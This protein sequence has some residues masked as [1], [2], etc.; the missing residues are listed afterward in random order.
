MKKKREFLKW[1]ISCLLT[2]CFLFIS[3]NTVV[4]ATE[5]EGA[6]V[7]FNS[8]VEVEKYEID[9]GYIE[10]GKENTI[11]LT[12]RN[13]NKHS[14]AN[15]IVIV[16]ASKSEMIYPSYGNDNQYYVGTLEATK[17]TT[18]EIPMV[19]DKNLHADYVDLVCDIVYETGKVK[20]T[21]S[22]V[23]VIP[24]QNVSNIIVDSINVG[25]NANVNGKSLLSIGYS[26]RSSESINDA[27]L[28]IDGN[29]SEETKKIKL[30]A[31]SAGK[32]Y[33][34]DCNVVFT[35]PGEQSI[36]VKL[37]YTDVK[38]N[39]IKSDLGSFKVN[40]TE[41]NNKETITDADETSLNR[42]G[43]IIAL[44]GGVLVALSIYVYL[45]KR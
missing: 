5:E 21:N 7:S 8:V 9:G 19:V 4:Y 32:S 10:A 24:T 27:V 29:V 3:S 18:V 23:M 25:T 34:K 22:C 35:V 26:N 44:V 16:L 33:T 1:G 30:G 17:S 36:Q 11:S 31:V 39:V 12:I 13:A 2:V 6:D 38:G 42:I 41:E 15:N 28:A 20:I 45:K 37:E 43:H 40:V 14:V